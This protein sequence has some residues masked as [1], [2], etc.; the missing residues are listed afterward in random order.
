[1]GLK[2]YIEGAT[3]RPLKVYIAGPI[4]GVVDYKENFE[5]AE[6]FLKQRGCIP[7]NPAVLPDNVDYKYAIDEGLKKLMEC[8][9]IYLL[10]GTAAS[11]GAAVEWNYAR[12]VGMLIITEEE[13][14]LCYKRIKE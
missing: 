3:N 7:V 5:R 1:M 12:T 13:N 10:R 2:T 8:D 11:K 14:K 4:S 9:A 6:K